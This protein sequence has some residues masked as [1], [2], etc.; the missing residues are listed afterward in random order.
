MLAIHT[1]LP[2]VQRYFGGWD[3]LLVWKVR[4]EPEEEGTV[5]YVDGDKGANQLSDGAEDPEIGNT[6]LTTIR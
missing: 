5:R 1:T 3:V 6:L 4:N 2:P